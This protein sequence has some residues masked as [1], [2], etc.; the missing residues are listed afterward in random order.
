MKSPLEELEEI[1]S[2]REAQ[3]LYTRLGRYLSGDIP[4]ASFVEGEGEA[5]QARRERVAKQWGSTQQVARQKGWRAEAR[6]VRRQ[7]EQQYGGAVR[8]T[9]DTAYASSAGGTGLK[10]AKGSQQV[11]L[12]T[13]S[14][15]KHFTLKK[16]KPGELSAPFVLYVTLDPRTLEPVGQFSTLLAAYQ[17]AARVRRAQQVIA[18]GISYEVA[19]TALLREQLDHVEKLLALLKSEQ[20]A[21]VEQLE[22]RTGQR[23]RSR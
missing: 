14:K 8:S 5:Q 17:K 10:E 23:R 18:R 1:T 13:W 7:L 6:E 20:T 21:L 12:P 19:A 16:P 11:T 15:R 22:A 2:Q 3:N 4:D 9:S